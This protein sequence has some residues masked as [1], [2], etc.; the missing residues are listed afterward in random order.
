M[1]D[2]VRA[3]KFSIKEMQQLGYRKS[4]ILMIDMVKKVVF[5]LG[6]LFLPQQIV[7]SVLEENYKM[8][9][10]YIVF[11]CLAILFQELLS[12]YLHKTLPLCKLEMKHRLE[13]KIGKGVMESKYE[14][15]ETQTFFHDLNFSKRCIEQESVFQVYTGMLEIFSGMLTMVGIT[16]LIF[17]ID[18]WIFSLIFISVLVNVV[19]EIIKMQYIYE[20]ERKS[21]EVDRNLYYARNDL[22]TNEFAKD[23]RLY[24]LYEFVSGKVALYANALCDLWSE[25]AVKSVKIVGWTYLVNG[26]QVVVVYGI[27]AYQCYEGKIAVNEFILYTSGIIG[28]GVVLKD[29]FTAIVVIFTQGKYINGIQNL[30]QEEETEVLEEMQAPLLFHHT[31]EFREVSFQYP[32]AETYA[33]KG[34][35]LK[36][37]KGKRYALVGR[38]GSGK[39]TFI[40]LL[41]GLYQPTSGEILVDDIPLTDGGMKSYW[42]L[43]SCVFQDFNI[44]GYSVRENIDFYEKSEE[45]N[46]E[47]VLDKVGL[48]KKISSLPQQTASIVNRELSTEGIM[49]SGGENQ[50]LA[51]ARAIHRKAEFYI[52]DEPTAALSPQNEI[53]LYQ[54]FN[55]MTMGKTVVFI[56]HRLA[57]C[58]LCDEILLLDYGT[59]LEKGSHEDL[60]KKEGLYYEM[61]QLQAKPYQEEVG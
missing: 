61:F 29:I 11:I 13:Q 48:W 59:L 47:E 46:I 53:Q 23:I 55:E 33:I 28:F 19:G 45:K 4:V 38:N 24:N 15:L 44:Y 22:A 1:K 37:E 21:G 58:K 8:A 51:I 39:T 40:K 3:L 31:I 34:L 2:I 5:S 6:M 16:W 43:F 9:L 35:N 30:M 20:R 42:K 14:K 52:L 50:L 26:I 36:I 7:K 17:S 25:A 60:M 57:S 49:L 18:H 12:A 10:Y 27:I 41:V 56:S 32:G 54:E